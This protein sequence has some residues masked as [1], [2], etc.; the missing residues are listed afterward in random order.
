VPR[1][2]EGFKGHSMYVLQRHI[3]K[4][5]V[6]GCVGGWGL[7]TLG[8]GGAVMSFTGLRPASPSCDGPGCAEQL[9]SELCCAVLC[10]AELC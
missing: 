2:V 8:P 10:C 4:Y 6:G 9:G 3:G 1:T 5:Q 7:G